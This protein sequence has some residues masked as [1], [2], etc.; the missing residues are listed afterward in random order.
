MEPHPLAAPCT[1][2]P[3]PGLPQ[4]LLELQR[5]LLGFRLTAWAQLISYPGAVAL[6]TTCSH[7]SSERLS[8]SL[9]DSLARQELMASASPLP[10][11][12]LASSRIFVDN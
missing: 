8:L 9:P 7:S 5:S 3:L 12:Q 4:G 11:N 10:R 2:F 1:L 6:D